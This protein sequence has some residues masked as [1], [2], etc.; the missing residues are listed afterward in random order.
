MMAM[1]VGWEEELM[2]WPSASRLVTMASS[3]YASSAGRSGRNTCRGTARMASVTAP[4]ITR[5]PPAITWLT[6]RS[7]SRPGSAEGTQMLSQQ[8]DRRLPQ[9]EGGHGERGQCDQPGPDEGV[10]GQDLQPMPV[11]L[12]VPGL[13]PVREVLG[14]AVPDPAGGRQALGRVP[15]LR[16]R[17]EHD[18]Q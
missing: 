12:V 15:E 14:R 4:E 9:P 2:G 3:W 8:A 5:R 1:I 6:M 10:A 7:R 16:P 13:V 17:S 11:E 18:Q